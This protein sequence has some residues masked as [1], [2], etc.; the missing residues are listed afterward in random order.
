MKPALQFVYS[1]ESGSS[2]PWPISP[3]RP[4]PPQLIHRDVLT[5]RFG[6]ER[7]L[8]PAVFRRA[9][10]ELQQWLDADARDA[11]GSMEDLQQPIQS[12]LRRNPPDRIPHHR[13]PLRQLPPP[14]V[15]VPQGRDRWSGQVLAGPNS[16]GPHPRR[17]PLSGVPSGIRPPPDDWRKTGPQDHPGQG[18]HQ[19]NAQKVSSRCPY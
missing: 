12:G 2:T 9:D 1:A 10:D 6:V 15:Q 8:L 3:T 19:G 17:S 16:R 11:C 14:P 18:L 13:H 4:F 7:V 5:E